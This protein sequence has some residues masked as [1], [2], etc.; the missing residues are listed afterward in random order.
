L[1]DDDDGLDEIVVDRNV[2]KSSNEE[3]V[4]ITPLGS[5]IIKN[6]AEKSHPTRPKKRPVTTSKNDAKKRRQTEAVSVSL[7]PHSPSKAELA[8]RLKKLPD[9]T[10]VTVTQIKGTSIQWALV[11]PSFTRENK[12]LIF[13]V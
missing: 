2:T 6:K 13:L 1:Q 9:E 10:N 12:L 5:S 11:G 3:A 8:Q 4:P 7:A